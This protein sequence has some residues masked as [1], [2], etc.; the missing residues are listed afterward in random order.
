MLTGKKC[1]LCRGEKPYITAYEIAVKHGFNGT[2]EEWIRSTQ[3]VYLARVTGNNQA[4]WQCSDTFADLYG[5]SEY[6]E[7]HLLTME[8][9]TAF[10]V[11]ISE[12]SMVFQTLP[13]PGD[14]GMVY[15]EYTLTR[16][17]VGL[18][19]TVDVASPGVGA[20]TKS[21]LS[22]EVQS[23]LDGAIQK[24]A[25]A[26]KT[27][28]T[29][30]RLR[31]SENGVLFDSEDV[32]VVN[33]Y[34]TGTPQIPVYEPDTNSS[35]IIAASQ[36]DKCVLCHAPEGFGMYIGDPNGEAEFIIRRYNDIIKYSIDGY[37][38]TR[39]RDVPYVKPAGGI[40]HS[41]LAND[42]V[43][44][45]NRAPIIGVVIKKTGTVYDV[46]WDNTDLHG[47]NTIPEAI[48]DAADVRAIISDGNT[49]AEHP[50]CYSPDSDTIVFAGPEYDTFGGGTATIVYYIVDA[51]QT[52]VTRVVKTLS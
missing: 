31:I 19:A 45:I 50:F 7:L 13:F 28:A 37:S 26:E 43:K 48:N 11:G 33:I 39:T 32:I 14:D 27:A 17:D 4:S 49:F 9:R 21:M 52:H 47:Y 44:D 6:S 10:C 22:S 30:K 8:G 36:T 20:I 2:E 38:V 34:N 42:L 23:L 15:E 25:Q 24:S 41:D 46:D 40:Q 16:A 5:K 51:T 29:D 1:C 12:N 3:S 18:V 35:A